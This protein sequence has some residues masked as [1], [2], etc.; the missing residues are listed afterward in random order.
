M[1]H[2]ADRSHKETDTGHHDEPVPELRIFGHD[3]RQAC[4]HTICRVLPEIRGYGHTGR[5]DRCHRLQ[6][7][8][9]ESRYPDDEQ[10]AE[11]SGLR[12]RPYQPGRRSSTQS[13]PYRREPD[14]G[15]DQ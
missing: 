1:A 14:H 9:P 11:G 4:I 10:R 7:S 3:G 5:C 2:T 6:L 15:T 12:F 13:R 8:D